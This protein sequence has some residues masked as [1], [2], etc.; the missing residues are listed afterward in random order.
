MIQSEIHQAVVTR[1]EPARE[2][3]P[4]VAAVG[5]GARDG[6]IAVARMAAPRA[7]RLCLPARGGL[8]EMQGLRVVPNIARNSFILWDNRS[9]RGRRKSGVEP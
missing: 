6:G 4:F 7:Q 3:G 1:V 8:G 2:F 9:C 5:G